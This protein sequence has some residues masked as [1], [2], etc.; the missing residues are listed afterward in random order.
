METQ[1]PLG[2]RLYTFETD[3]A[4]QRT[5]LKL[6]ADSTPAQS[7]QPKMQPM[8]SVWLVTASSGLPLFALTPNPGDQSFR[9]LTA[10]QL[11]ATRTQWF[12]PLADNYRARVWTNPESTTPGTPT[13][14]SYKHFTWQQII[15]FAE[16]DRPSM[17]YYSGLSGDWK[18]APDGGAGYLLVM[19]GGDPYWTD[20]IGQIPFAVDTYK[21]Y[22]ARQGSADD[23]IRETVKTGISWGDGTL[24]GSSDPTNEYDNYMVLRGAL[25]A[26]ENHRLVKRELT[27][28]GADYPQ[29]YEVNEAV[30]APTGN[31]HL[32]SPVDATSVSLYGIW[33]QTK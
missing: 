19:V 28:M 22:Y 27:T 8:P 2:G 4:T 21:M 7:K 20:A 14:Q 32:T 16:V 25:W 1:I 26:K 5:A 10:R 29:T 6:K 24:F 3:T 23:A 31:A 11:Y 15:D 18:Q 13:Y 33:K 30:F 9:I 12:E 17:K